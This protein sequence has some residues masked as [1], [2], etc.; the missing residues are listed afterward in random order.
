MVGTWLFYAIR[1]MGFFYY[2]SFEDPDEQKSWLAAVVAENTNDGM[3]N[4][5]YESWLLAVS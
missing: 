3:S 2:R 4:N 1:K 5:D